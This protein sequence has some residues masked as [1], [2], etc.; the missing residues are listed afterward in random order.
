MVARNFKTRG[1][2]TAAQIA[3]HWKTVAKAV[4]ELEQDNSSAHAQVHGLANRLGG[5]LPPTSWKGK[6]QPLLLSAA[7]KFLWFRG[8]TSIRIYD[9]RAKD[10]LNVMQKNRAKSAGKRE[11]KVDSNYA[12]FADAWDQE[13]NEHKHLIDAAIA[14]LPKQMDWSIIPCGPERKMATKAIRET[15]FADRVFDKFLW[16]IGSSGTGAETFE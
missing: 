15:W 4:C 3:R 16:T 6:A 12:R 5:I 9:K 10:A 8:H 7:S 14:A 1:M 11:W 2:T 13:F